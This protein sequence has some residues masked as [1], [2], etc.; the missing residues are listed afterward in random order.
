MCLQSERIAD[1]E[2]VDRHDSWC[3]LIARRPSDS[4]VILVQQNCRKAFKKAAEG[5]KGHEKRVADHA[6][7]DTVCLRACTRIEDAGGGR[8]FSV[9]KR[10][11]IGVNMFRV[12]FFFE[13]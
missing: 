6:A 2:D 5:R 13:K 3:A 10:A 11:A 4:C 12:P 9:A 7:L 1:D 8:M